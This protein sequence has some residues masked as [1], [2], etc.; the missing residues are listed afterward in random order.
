MRKETK[1]EKLSEQSRVREDS[2]ICVNRL[3][4]LHVTIAAGNKRR[5][6]DDTAIIVTRTRRTPTAIY[7]QL[8]FS[9]HCE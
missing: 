2:H 4:R 9:S 7:A 1:T 8:E 3:V 6:I 5:Q